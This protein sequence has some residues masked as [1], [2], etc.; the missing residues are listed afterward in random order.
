MPADDSAMF[1]GIK[2]FNDVIMEAGPDGNIQSE[3]ILQKDASTFTFK[4]G[5][6]FPRKIY[7]NGDECMMPPA[8]LYP[9]LPN[10]APRYLLSVAVLAAASALSFLYLL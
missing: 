8:D 5:W 3:V 4:E 1:Y 2:F 9:H 6:A 10:S 7:F